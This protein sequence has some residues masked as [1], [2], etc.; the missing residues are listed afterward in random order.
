MNVIGIVETSDELV[1]IV[2]EYLNKLKSI[3]QEKIRFVLH[4]LGGNISKA[5]ERLLGLPVEVM[6]NLEDAVSKAVSLSK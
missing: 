6:E 2:C 1:T 3:D 4:L 5:R